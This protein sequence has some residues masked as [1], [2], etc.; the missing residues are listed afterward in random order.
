MITGLVSKNPLV[1]KIID[2]GISEEIMDLFFKKELPL[3]EEEYLECLILILK[4]DGLRSMVI[5]MIN[6]ISEIAKS[7]YIEK[8]E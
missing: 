8:K 3:T 4:K 6:N 5:S 2:G 1:E 7:N